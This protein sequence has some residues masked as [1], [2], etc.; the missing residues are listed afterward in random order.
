MKINMCKTLMIDDNP[1]E[2]LI[3]QKMFDRYEIFE[4]SVHTLDAALIINFL[5]ENHEDISVL[6]DLI[7][8]DLNM[9]YSGWQFLTDLESL[10]PAL[11]K[12]PHVFIVSSSIDGS[13]KQRATTFAA[14]KG[15]ISKPVVKQKLEEIA[16]QYLPGKA[17]VN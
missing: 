6:P 16:G 2:H 7:F 5:E 11:Q 12:Q 3:M 10:M 1:M 4:D 17:W 13:D 15:F 8:L 14:V 9:P